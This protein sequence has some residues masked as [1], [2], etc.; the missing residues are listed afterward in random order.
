MSNKN[1]IG[2]VVHRPWGTYQS[3]LEEKGYQIKKIVVHP[4][5]QLSL[6]YHH[7]RSEHWVVTQGE[8][9][10]EINKKKHDAKKGDYFFIPLK[11]VHRLSNP[12]KEPLIIVEIQSGDYLGEDDIVRLEDSYGRI[13]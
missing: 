3:L 6:Q 10:V 1:I 12:G 11:A 7:Q 13:D 4:N 8:G 2:E 9:I 5:E